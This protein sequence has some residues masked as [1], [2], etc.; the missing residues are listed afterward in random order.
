MRLQAAQSEALLQLQAAQ[1]EAPLHQGE[2]TDAGWG[3]APIQAAPLQE[4]PA[5]RR[6][7]STVSDSLVSATAAGPPDSLATTAGLP[8]GQHAFAGASV[9]PHVA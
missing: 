6:R 9:K 3:Q 4:A 1:G 8:D 2:A 5:V 7:G